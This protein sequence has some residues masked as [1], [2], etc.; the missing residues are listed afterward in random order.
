MLVDSFGRKITY[1]RLS[2]TD[3]CNL[4]CV[5][6][7]PEIYNRF[8]PSNELL[9]DDEIVRLISVFGSLGVS[10]LRITGGEPLLRPR[11]VELIERL[12]ATSGLTDISLST[13]GLL[14]KKLAKDMR[15]AGLTRVNVSLDS[16]N[17]EK[18]T[19]IT[20]FG[21]IDDVREGLEAA[22]DAGFSPVKI[23]VVVMKGV[24]DD[25]I[26]DFAALTE[27]YPFHVR[28]IELMPMGETGFF[29]QDRWLSFDQ[30]FQR[31]A[32]LEEI[33]PAEKPF[34]QGPARYFRRPGAKGT[35]GFIS[36]L[37]CGFCSACNRVRLTSSGTLV[38]CLDSTQGT[39]LKSLLRTGASDEE[40]GQTIRNVITE[41]PERHFMV[42]RAQASTSNP[43]FMCQVGG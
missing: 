34:G 6:C 24:N 40:L 10:S 19:S 28:F 43:R 4:R 1:V 16:L 33:P 36:A 25:E 2:I 5:Y 18:F 20:R 27:R 22:Q 35:V 41:K 11:I 26:E 7:L 39:D 30:I 17:P 32:P 8:S 29:S 14:L 42:D 3:R 31:A 38:P 12:H 23:N 9:T 15:K 13:N 37:S 21:T